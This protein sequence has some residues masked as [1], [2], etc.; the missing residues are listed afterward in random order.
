MSIEGMVQWGGNGNSWFMASNQ[1]LKCLKQLAEASQERTCRPHYRPCYSCLSR[2]VDVC[3]ALAP[4]CSDPRPRMCTTAG[5]GTPGAL[6]GLSARWS[7]IDRLYGRRWLTR[8][9][10]AWW[11]LWS[12]GCFEHKGVRMRACGRTTTARRSSPVRFLHAFQKFAARRAATGPG[13]PRPGRAALRPTA[14]QWTMATRAASW[15]RPSI[16]SLDGWV[17]KL[18]SI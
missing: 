8:K 12:S 5:P 6:P 14:P 2:A 18:V 3:I 11:G 1:C 4:R 17:F 10:Y 16:R 7:A 9:V 13:L 15:S